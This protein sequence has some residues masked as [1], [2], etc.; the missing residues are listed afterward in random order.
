MVVCH[1]RCH[2]IGNTSWWS[3]QGCKEG[4]RRRRQRK[5]RWIPCLLFFPG[6][7]FL[8][9]RKIRLRRW[10]KKGENEVTYLLFIHNWNGHPSMTQLT[11]ALG[12]LSAPV[13][14]ALACQHSGQGELVTLVA[15]VANA[16]APCELCAHNLSVGDVRWWATHNRCEQTNEM[17][18]LPPT[19][20]ICSQNLGACCPTVLY[21]YRE[22]WCHSRCGP[23]C[24]WGWRHGQR[25]SWIQENNERW[26]CGCRWS[27]FLPSARWLALQG[28]HSWWLHK[29]KRMNHVAAVANRLSSYH[30]YRQTPTEFV[31][32]T[33][34]FALSAE[35]VPRILK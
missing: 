14:A 21:L 4:S 26:R 24:R 5:G 11:E 3:P 10:R 9:L 23:W 30:I 1:S 8:D 22:A 31:L 35:N 34:F 28:R 13:T 16:W 15:G 33:F 6:L 20:L 18:F 19:S 17:S 25:P 12:F 2:H 32:E 29:Q 27:R 7:V